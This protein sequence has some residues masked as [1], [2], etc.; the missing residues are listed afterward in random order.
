MQEKKLCLTTDQ[1]SNK[2]N[3]TVYCGLNIQ[4]FI[5]TNLVNHNFL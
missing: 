5:A 4:S 3:V 2:K 1:G